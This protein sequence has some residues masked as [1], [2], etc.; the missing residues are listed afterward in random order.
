[1]IEERLDDSDEQR[2]KLFKDWLH[3]CPHGEFHSI[4]ETWD[5]EATLGF[6]VDFAVCRKLER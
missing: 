3:Q 2:V 6:R 5:D 1:M 4:E